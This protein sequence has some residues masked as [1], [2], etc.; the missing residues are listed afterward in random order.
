VPRRPEEVAVFE[1]V[2]I[3]RDATTRVAV[4]SFLARYREPTLTPTGLT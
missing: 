2:P 4:A 3:D 1:L